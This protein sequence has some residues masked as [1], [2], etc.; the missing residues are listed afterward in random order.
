MTRSLFWEEIS[1]KNLMMILGLDDQGLRY[2]EL[3]MGDFFCKNFKINFSLLSPTTLEFFKYRFYLGSCHQNVLRYNYTNT[4][5]YLVSL[6]LCTC[7]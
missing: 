7:I 4:M 2:V 5:G 3:R 6:N 1:K